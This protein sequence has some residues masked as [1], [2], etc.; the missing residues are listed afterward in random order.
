MSKLNLANHMFAQAK[1]YGQRAALKYRDLRGDKMWKEFS[2]EKLGDDV[3]TL[4]KSLLDFGVKEQGVIA[5]FSQNMC[6]NLVVDFAAFTNRAIVTP[7]YATSSLAQVSYIVNDAAIELL[8]VGEQ[9]QYD[10]AVQA[11]PNCPSLKCIVA[12]DDEIKFSPVVNSIYYKD[13]LAKGKSLNNEAEL[14]KI[15]DGINESEDLA[16]ILYTSGTTGDPK[17]AMLTHKGVMSAMVSHS[18]RF[19]YINDG[20]TSI[21]FLP[22]SHVYERMWSYFCLYMGI[23]TT[24]NLR[25]QEIQ[26]VVKEVRPTLMCSVPRFWEKVH[27]GIQDILS[28]YSPVKLAMV[29]WALATGKKYNVETLRLGK[30][31]SWWLSAK[32]QVADKL[33]YSK[34][35]NTIGI[36]NGKL[37]PVGGAAL[38]DNIA[39]F[40]R[41]IGVPIC[42]GYGLTESHA[43]VTC[44]DEV[45]YL[46]GSVGRVMP[47]L[48]VRIGED[49]EV[50]L[51]GAT[52]FKGYYNKPEINAQAFTEDG[53][54]RTGDS[55]SLKDGHLFLLDRIKDLFKTSNG[56]YIAPQQIET[57]I[58]SDEYIEQIAVI[59]DKRNY[60]TAIVVPNVPLLEK[61]ATSKQIKYDGV[62][63]LLA[64]PVIYSFF[65]ERI[66]ALQSKL[67]HYEQIKK[68]TLIKNG[69]AIE[70]GELTNTLKIRRAVIMQKYAETINAMYEKG[71]GNALLSY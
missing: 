44:Y 66:N 71:R 17:G 16:L 33:I 52:I 32:Y 43:T 29:T 38:S 6:E 15:T 31:P 67:A 11:V 24:I 36:E 22:L 42:L 34:V 21:A 46:F 20:D 40:F 28:S 37:F 45:G 49:N 13:L 7:I 59:G 56:K 2:W 68:F 27:A 54:F 69:F 41:S 51:R 62:E 61:Y 5:Q 57:L 23:V 8:F 19:P 18:E 60:V 12:F 47:H 26:E 3:Y 4:A 64:N 9:K 25:P 10:I 63:D 14:N 55:G 58:S 39:M 65:E 30:K 48:E 50:Q 53:F 1:K 35:K 70:T